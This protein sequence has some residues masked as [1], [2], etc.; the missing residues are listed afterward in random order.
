MLEVNDHSKQCSTRILELLNAASP[1]Y[2]ALWVPGT[3]L[4]LREV[5]EGSQGVASGALSESAL[6]FLCR[7]TLG[8]VGPDPGTG[9]STQNNSLST[10]LKPDHMVFQGFGYKTLQS[11]ADE[12][13]ANYLLRWAELLKRGERLPPPENVACAI[14]SHLLDAG[15]SSDFL[16]RWWTYRVRYEPTTLTLAEITADAHRMVSG[17]ENNFE[18]LILFS[19]VPPFD[20]GRPQ[21]WLDAHTAS[22]W[23]KQNGFPVEGIRQK[24]GAVIMT[25]ARDSFSSVYNA[26]EIINQFARRVLL[27]SR[28][29]LTPV[30]MGWVKGQQEPIKFETT[31]QTVKIRT[32]QRQAQVFS[33]DKSSLV[34]AAIELLGPVIPLAP[35][36]VISGAWAAIEALLSAPGDRDRGACQ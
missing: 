8:L 21:G 5:L 6:E 28:G 14:A 11:I 25:T 22:N 20:A 2:R 29:K 1:W 34:D 17:H 33:G 9:I 23:L 26:F 19:E 15:F 10:C 7:S 27:G 18:V 13:D 4:A 30:N 36:P 3:S 31:R 24:G 12:V 16:H 32:L 35:T